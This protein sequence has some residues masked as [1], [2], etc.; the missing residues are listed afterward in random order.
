VEPDV[1]AQLDSLRPHLARSALIS[2]RLEL[3]RA[4]QITE[5]LD[6]LALPALVFDPDGR[7]LAA[8]PLIEDLKA[9]LHWRAQD[10][11]SLR[12]PSADVLLQRAVI[13]LSQ[14]AAA[15][16]TADVRS[17]AVRGDIAEP[18]MVA[19]VIP[20]RGA[21]RDVF[22]RCAG[23]LVLTPVVRPQALPLELVQ[24]LFDLTPAEARVARGLGAGDTVED[25]AAKSGLSPVTIRNQVRG[26]LQKTGSRRQAD[27][28]ALLG[29]AGKGR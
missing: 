18:S 8:N 17:F 1:V 4:N 6:L 23:V 11:I 28:I 12:D 9:T 13:G 14:P 20:I 7:V 15:T 2:A 29:V 3:Q 26:V 22:V 19:H 27:L 25:I 10:R 21:A 24:S 16:A 5:T